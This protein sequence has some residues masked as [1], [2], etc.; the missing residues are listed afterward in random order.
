[1]RY[2]LQAQALRHSTAPGT[3]GSPRRNV[4]AASAAE[5]A[6]DAPHNASAL[7]QAP[8]QSR[9]PRRKAVAPADAPP[10]TARAGASDRGESASGRDSSSPLHPNGRAANATAPK[11]G[12]PPS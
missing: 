1:H 5:P 10:P 4:P 8:R 11:S 9:A 2:E 3:T 12:T 7:P 6:E